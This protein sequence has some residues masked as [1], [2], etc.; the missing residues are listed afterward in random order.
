MKHCSS[1]ASDP[2]SLRGLHGLCREKL[3]EHRVS[4]SRPA[5]SKIRNFPAT[6]GKKSS[7][8]SAATPSASKSQKATVFGRPLRD[9]APST[10]ILEDT[11]DLL[12]PHFLVAILN[13]LRGHLDTDGLFRKA[14]SAG[15]Q[16]LLRVDIEEAETFYVDEKTAAISALDVGSLLKQWLR[17]LPE[18]LIPYRFHDTFTK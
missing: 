8:G 6:P 12:V 3:K 14:G 10:V 16:K 18:P 13:F 4:A 17:E 5:K 15:R 9:L 11:D 7:N 2:E 1:F